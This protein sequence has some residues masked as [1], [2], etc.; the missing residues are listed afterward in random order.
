VAFS[1]ARLVPQTAL[2]AAPVATLRA[3]AHVHRVRRLWRRAASRG[4][5]PVR[6]MG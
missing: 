2:A 5:H 1:T 4:C 3:L 6:A